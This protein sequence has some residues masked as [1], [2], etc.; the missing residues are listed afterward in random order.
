MTKSVT[1]FFLLT[2]FAFSAFG[3]RSK[4]INA[5]AKR[6]TAR[7]DGITI[8][9]EDVVI[10]TKGNTIYSD[11]AEYNRNNETCIAYGNLKIKT[12]QKSI[13][14][15]KT[16]DCDGLTGVIN[17]DGDVVMTDK[18]VVMKTP[19][20]RYESMEDI[21]HYNQ[22]AEIT[23]GEAVLV[24][25][26][27]DYNGKTGVFDCYEDVVVTH[28]DYT[29][30]T[31]TMDYNKNGMSNF[32]GPTDIITK[33]HT[34]YCENGWYDRKKERVNLR[35]NAFIEMKD[36]Q[37]LFGDSINYS[38]KAKQG[39]AF[40]NVVFLDTMKN[41]TL[42]S[43]YAENN[44]KK[45]FAFFSHNARGILVEKED[46]LFISSD[47]MRVFYEIDKS[48]SN[49][50]LVKKMEAFKRVRIFRNDLQAICQLMIYYQSDS[51]LYLIDKPVMW[52]SGFQIDGDTIKT[53]FENSRPHET[54]VGRNAFITALV[55]N[56]N[57]LYHQI[58]GRNLW[59][60]YNDD[61]QLSSAELKGGKIEAIYYVIDEEKGELVGVNKSISKML[62]MYFDSGTIYK[63]NFIEPESTILYPQD[64]LTAREQTLKGFHWL[65]SLR[66]KS[67]WDVSG[68]W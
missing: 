29:I 65:E 14:T 30:Y 13:I 9:R 50:R 43:E 45:G 48:D 51:L 32:K 26:W 22:K 2:L 44:E 23:S 6:A 54:L 33:D 16:L 61:S 17:I 37:R 3:Q 1:L 21:A 63:V 24:S 41:C 62:R 66:P 40:R 35:T 55:Q 49:K 47:T 7:S 20:L 11:Y 34:M 39:E 53:W 4:G 15:G 27:G 58:K 56:S 36:G 46:T 5:T 52:N 38:L 64:Q 19:S 8:F 68:V 25:S 18:D 12:R 10:R 57:S 60:Y 59:G 28:P 67:K 42:K 31:D